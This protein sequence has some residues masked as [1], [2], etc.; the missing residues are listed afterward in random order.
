MSEIV[1]L[2]INADGDSFA[3]FMADES[4]MVYW[5]DDA[6]GCPVRQRR[7]VRNGELQ[8][9][10]IEILKNDWQELLAKAESHPMNWQNKVAPRMMQLYADKRAMK[11]MKLE[12][13]HA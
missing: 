8:R 4:W 12:A 7:W 13:E 6:N 2:R 10:M 11:Q 5:F 3:A 9:G 1:H